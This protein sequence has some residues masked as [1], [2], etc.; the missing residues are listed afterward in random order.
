[1]LHKKYSLN[2]GNLHR[3]AKDEKGNALKR[4]ESIKHINVL[5]T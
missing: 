1:V 2:N 5:I 4:Q 3:N